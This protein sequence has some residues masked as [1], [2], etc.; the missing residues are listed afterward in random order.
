MSLRRT[1]LATCAIA[2]LGGIGMNSASAQ[3]APWFRANFENLNQSGNNLY[4]FTNRY[5][6]STTTWQTTHTTNQGYG[7]SAAP[8]VTIHGCSNSSPTCNLSEHQ[9]NAGWT[10]PALGGTRSMGSP[11]FIRYRIKFDPDTRFP[12]GGFR[13]KFI[14]LGSTGGSPNSR[15]IIHLLSPRDNQG[16]SLGFDSYGSMGWSPS[17]STTWWTGQQFGLGA[18]FGT[19]SLQDRYA[20][21]QSSVNIG[22]SCAPA[23]LVAPSN[24]PS[25]APKPQNRGERSTDGWYH[26]QFE[27]V[28]GNNGAAD[29]RIWA[30]NNN[31]SSPSSEH[32]NMI[33]GLGITNWTGSVDVVGYWQTQFSGSMNFVIDDFEVGPAFDANWFPASGPRPSPPTGV[34]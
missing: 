28:P 11:V 18:E 7:G 26:L 14:M 20:G 29:F 31:Q 16:C 34:N 12:A 33:D 3:S 6:Q 21:F 10:T 30:N 22:W 2:L 8:R 17:S 32:Q 27:A 25:P 24:H 13:A 15:W 19:S 9:F 1:S 23:V 5:P 4:N